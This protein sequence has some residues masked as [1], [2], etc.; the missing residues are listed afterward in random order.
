[1]RLRTKL[2]IAAG[3]SIAVAGLVKA[4]RGWRTK[5]EVTRHTRGA[6]AMVGKECEVTTLEVSSHFGQ[7]IV[8]DGGPGMIVSIRCEEPNELARGSR[9]RIVAYHAGSDS[10]S[11]ELV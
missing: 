3:A 5:S 8:Q 9:A 10:Y 7:G 2:A 6:D 11:V 1:M 4:V